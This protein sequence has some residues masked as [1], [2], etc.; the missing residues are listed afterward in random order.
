[1]LKFTKPRLDWVS[2]GKDAWR[3]GNPPAFPLGTYWL[4]RFANVTVA[5]T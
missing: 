2:F 1:M 5:E 4:R 3:D